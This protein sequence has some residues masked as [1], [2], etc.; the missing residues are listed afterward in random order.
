MEQ[1]ERNVLKKEYFQLMKQLGY[2]VVYDLH[3]KKHDDMFDLELLCTHKVNDEVLY[4]M[5]QIG[6]TNELR[7]EKYK[8]YR[9]NGKLDEFRQGFINWITH[10]TFNVNDMIACLL[11]EGYHI[12]E[13][14]IDNKIHLTPKIIKTVMDS[15]CRKGTPLKHL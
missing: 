7:V 11:H 4:C 6:K 5:Y 9:D 2:S 1:N 3:T 13:I 14:Y 10:V 8:E 15:L 12:E